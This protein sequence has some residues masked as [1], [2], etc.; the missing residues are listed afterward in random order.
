MHSD[1]DFSTL[2]PGSPSFVPQPAPQLNNNNNTTVTRTFNGEPAIPT[3][4]D[5]EWFYHHIPDP[6]VDRRVTGMNLQSS[7]DCPTEALIGQNLNPFPYIKCPN[8]NTLIKFL[9]VQYHKVDNPGESFLCDS[10]EKANRVLSDGGVCWLFTSIKLKRLGTFVVT[11]YFQF[12]D[13]NIYFFELPSQITVVKAIRDAPSTKE[14]P[15]VVQSLFPNCQPIG[16][17]MPVTVEGN[18]IPKP[19]YTVFFGDTI[20]SILSATE[21][22]IRVLSPT[23]DQEGTVLVKVCYGR[24]VLEKSLFYTYYTPTDYKQALMN[25]GTNTQ[26]HNPAQ[27][28]M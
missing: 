5:Y 9:G 13:D 17:E 7:K 1:A 12:Q 11:L 10:H 28:E 8:E 15:P 18:F 24:T 19:N 27:T 16:M 3:P 2:A 6:Q 22:Q 23:S 26:S 14:I 4:S 25:N 20:A 21:H